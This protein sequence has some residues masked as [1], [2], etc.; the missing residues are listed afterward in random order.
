VDNVRRTLIGVVLLAL[1]L[2]SIGQALAERGGEVAMVTAL[3]GKVSRVAPLGPQPVEAFAKL[4]HG[5]LLALDKDSRLQVVYF[6]GGRQETWHGPGR[7]EIAKIDSTPY[8]LQAPEIKALPAV[9]VRQIAQTPL[10]ASQGRAGMVRLRSAASAE[11]LT[12]V[13]DTYRQLRQATG[14]DDINPELFLL[15]ALFELQEFDRVERAL[16]QLQLDHAG[17]ADAAAAAELYGKAVR[18]SREA[19]ERN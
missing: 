14:A 11:D 15:S 6:E 3:Q 5:D 1:V 4:Q 16:A 18:N 8:G 13:E 2:A 17:N 10:L 19:N 9:L 12:K 7:L